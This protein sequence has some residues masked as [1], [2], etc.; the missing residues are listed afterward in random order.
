M[1]GV[2]AGLNGTIFCFGQTGAG[3]TYTMSGEAQQYARRGIVPRALHQLFQ[4]VELR[5]DRSYEVKVSFLEIYNE[6]LYDLL[7]PSPGAPDALH[8][9]EERD[10]TFV[11]GLT[12]VPV[13]SEE[14]AL[15]C[16]F[17]GESARSTAEHT[18]NANSS[19]SHSIFTVQV[20][21]RSAGE[22][23][24]RSTCSKLSLVDLA[25]SERTK[26]TGVTGQ[27]MREANCINKSLT[28]LEQAVNALSRREAHVP[29][30]QSKLTSVLRDALGG[31]CRTV[32]IANVWPEAS[33]LEETVSTLRFASRVR[34]IETEAYVAES[35]D[36]SL[37][38]KRYERQVKE[39]KA[40]LA[41]R[42][43]LN[44]RSAVNYGDLSEAEAVEL[45]ALVKRFLQGGEQASLVDALPCD[46]LKRVRDVYRQ[47]QA[48]YQAAASDAE[49]QQAWLL[50]LT[51]ALHCAGPAGSQARPGSSPG[52]GEPESSGRGFS[53]GL[54]PPGL[55]PPTALKDDGGFILKRFTAEAAGEPPIACLGAGIEPTTDC[56]G[57]GMAPGGSPPRSP[58]SPGIAAMRSPGRV[59]SPGM[60]RNA[61]F[62]QFKAGVGQQLN[63]TL[64]ERQAALKAQREAAKACSLAVNA[65]KA[66]IDALS[67]ELQDKS[68]QHGGAMPGGVLDS[69]QFQLMQRLKGLKLDYRRMFDD[70][71]EARDRLD[72]AVAA[73]A[74]ARQA[75]IDAFNSW[76]DQ[77]HS[78]QLAFGGSPLTDEEGLDASEA[79]DQLQVSRMYAQDPDSLAFHAA[80]KQVRSKQTKQS[81]RSFMAVR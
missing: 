40:E 79:F 76:F 47:M 69:E 42:D 67:A 19:R 57:A 35:T 52:M 32:M 43:M 59:S 71:R 75:L 10:V 22:G 27:Q 78:G 72:P 11:R 54:A 13:H 56:L 31:N 73:A 64:K 80:R 46:T 66:S 45:Q 33:H 8:I 60:D 53:V 77:A 16:F 17:E 41:M 68:A 21:V 70:L 50:R 30:R 2:L 65:A 49:K 36:P 38:I 7:S 44:G 61:A 1:E 3:K 25:G 39:L 55:R 26:K 15:A 81:H 62:L 37:L 28:F 48:L 9:L 34:L 20:Q 51:E 63:Q 14:Q 12:E 5:V 6:T 18:L 74:A 23:T 29:Y 58:G 4:E 24:E